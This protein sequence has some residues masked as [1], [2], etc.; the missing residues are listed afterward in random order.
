M[1]DE[2]FPIGPAPQI[3]SMTRAEREAHTLALRALPLQ[4]RAALA[5]LNDAQLDTPYREGGWTL[6]Q[7]AHHV[8]DSHLNA[9]VRTK[10]VLTEP[11]PV[12][13]T[14]E[15]DPWAQLPDAA[16][17]I[18]PSLSL[19]D[20]LHLRWAALFESLDDQG[21]AR[22]FIHPELRGPV[23]EGAPSWQRAFNAD[24]RGRVNLDQFLAAY[25]WHGQHHTAH[26]LHLRERRGW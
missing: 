19:L 20:G 8:P 10:L 9:Y 2:R 22:C 17:P 11:E 4:F 26:I 25:V 23:P 12:I 7:L 14:W 3:R 21:F 5:D 24:E 6:R 15:V 16:L 13:K 1:S 18:E